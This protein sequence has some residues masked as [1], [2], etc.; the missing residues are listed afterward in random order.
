M[1]QYSYCKICKKEV[2]KPARKPMETFHKVIWIIIIIASVGIAAII[3][4][5]YYYNRKKIYCPTCNAKLEFSSKPFEKESEEEELIPLTPKEKVLKKA[6]KKTA[7]KKRPKEGEAEEAEETKRIKPETTFCPY[8]GEDIKP[9]T[10]RCP[11][12]GSSLKLH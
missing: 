7:V 3:F 5:I 4:V 2:D 12:C 11:Y 8:C 10:K 9:D 1:V 6:G